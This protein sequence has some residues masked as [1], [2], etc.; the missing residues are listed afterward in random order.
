MRASTMES[1]HETARSSMTR[2]NWNGGEEEDEPGL[3]S[4]MSME[5]LMEELSTTLGYV[6]EFLRQVPE[7]TRMAAIM[8]VKMETFKKDQ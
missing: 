4:R 3:G 7:S 5:Q 2:D 6:S 8:W 1:F